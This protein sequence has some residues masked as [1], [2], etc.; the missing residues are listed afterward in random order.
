MKH[1]AIINGTAPDGTPMSVQLYAIVACNWVTPQTALLWMGGIPIS[2]QFTPF[3][4]D[5][6]GGA[7]T[8]SR[9]AL[10][11]RFHGPRLP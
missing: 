9:D 5:D 1:S 10:A 6:R 4:D 7:Y 11:G 8:S 2:F 3:V